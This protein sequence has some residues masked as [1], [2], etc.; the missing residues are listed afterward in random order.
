MS[1][2]PAAAARIFEAQALFINAAR[3]LRVHRV[4]G[5]TANRDVCAHDV[6]FSIGQ[7]PPA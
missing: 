2:T 3:T 1:Q 7:P 5:I 4:E 6:D